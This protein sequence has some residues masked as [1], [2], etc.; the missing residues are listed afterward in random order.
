MENK[1]KIKN[2]LLH[3]L[4]KLNAFWSYNAADISEHTVGDE[5]FIEKSLRYLDID[6]L[7]KL[8]LLYPHKK[9]K[10]VWKTQLC[11]LV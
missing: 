6:D 8:F 9:I 10:E 7:K 3:T 5:L 1:Q 4:Q 2:N 11:T